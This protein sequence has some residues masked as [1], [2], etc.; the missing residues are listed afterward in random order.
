MENQIIED[1]RILKALYHGNH[2]NELELNRAI[3]ILYDL[4]KNMKGRLKLEQE[5]SGYQTIEQRK[6]AKLLR[7][8]EEKKW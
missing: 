5:L 4:T 8:V 3:K 7:K 2:L 6:K 1:L